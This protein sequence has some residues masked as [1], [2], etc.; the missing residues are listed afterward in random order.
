MDFGD[1]D[2][3][4]DANPFDGMDYDGVM[5]WLS[6]HKDELESQGIDPETF[7]MA[8]IDEFGASP[9][10]TASPL[11]MEE[12]AYKLPIFLSQCSTQ[13]LSQAF[14]NFIIPAALAVMLQVFA[15]GGMDIPVR[16]AISFLSGLMILIR[17][18]TFGLCLFALSFVL[19]WMN[20]AAI[21]HR[22]YICISLPL[23]VLAAEVC[24]GEA[25]GGIRGP[26]LV[27]LLKFLSVVMTEGFNLDLD[28][29]SHVVS[30][31]GYL[32]HPATMLLGPWIPY[33]MYLRSIENPSFRITSLLLVV[34]ASAFLILSTC[35][36]S[37]FE[38]STGWFGE[39]NDTISFH[40][41]HYYILYVTQM[42]V[43][44]GGGKPLKDF[45]N[46]I[47]VFFPFELYEVCR[48]WNEPVHQFLREF[49]F[50]PAKA[51]HST[52]YAIIS[53]FLASA[54]LHG[55]NF[56]IFC[57]LM[58]LGFGSFAEFEFRRKVG[59]NFDLP[60]ILPS[61]I[62]ER[63]EAKLAKD[64]PLR[65]K[66][67]PDDSTEGVE[68]VPRTSLGKEFTQAVI[69]FAFLLVNYYHLFFLGSVFGVHDMSVVDTVIVFLS[70]SMM[71]PCII[72]G[73]LF[74]SYFI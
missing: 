42:L 34:P 27:F 56:P 59:T 10:T 45:C 16:H 18:Q 71:S 61:R 37:L 51:Q 48:A 69:N 50:I 39:V 40:C 2:D 17:F 32:F 49:V 3:Y 13:V 68:D 66:D 38:K 23:V 9:T 15:H 35:V 19:V 74:Y 65:N 30:L 67:E 53:T 55:L 36:S 52:F 6:N 72:A 73:L 28:D 63:R 29:L 54:I 46:P 8:V 25:W 60:K 4:E 64:P 11:T 43:V 22:R 20:I 70:K 1:Y 24:V 44:L 12:I 21:L 7:K 47:K 57:T 33:S 62:R 14:D 41:S 5:E 58:I 26:M 31:L